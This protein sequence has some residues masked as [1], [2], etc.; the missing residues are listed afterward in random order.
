M[1]ADLLVID[2][3][4]MAGQNIFTTVTKRLQET[5][6]HYKDKSFGNLSMVLLRVFKQLPPVCD[7]LLFKAN[8][9]NHSG[10]NIYQLFDK[11]ITF[12]EPRY[13][14]ESVAFSGSS[15]TKMCGS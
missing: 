1:L 7:A 4:R 6:P 12:T 15:F 10:I 3:K 14:N 13:V 5:R 2:E 8:A 11:A 9:V